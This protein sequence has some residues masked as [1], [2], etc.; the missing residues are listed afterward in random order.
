M[1][2]DATIRM[3]LPSAM[4]AEWER[5]ASREAKSLSDWIRE[6]VETGRK[7]EAAD[8]NASRNGSVFRDLAA[9]LE[10]AASGD[11]YEVTLKTKPHPRRSKRERL[12]GK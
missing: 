12:A 8:A 4:K 5:S 9:L 11:G 3:R 2:N 7:R 6:K 1:S 10:R